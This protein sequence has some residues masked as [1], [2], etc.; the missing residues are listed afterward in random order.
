MTAFFKAH[1][2]ERNLDNGYF[3]LASLQKSQASL[4]YICLTKRPYLL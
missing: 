3:S 2:F 1:L 4:I